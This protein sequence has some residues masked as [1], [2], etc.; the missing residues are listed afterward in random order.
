MDVRAA[1]LPNARGKAKAAGPRHGNGT[2]VL[3]PLRKKNPPTKVG[4]PSSRVR[5]KGIYRAIAG[6]CGA[7]GFRNESGL[8]QRFGRQPY[9]T[10]FGHFKRR[11]APSGISLFYFRLW[12]CS[13]MD[14]HPKSSVSIEQL[15]GQWAVQ[16]L[17]A[18]AVTKRLFEREEF[19]RNYAASQ[20]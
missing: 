15:G 14:E 16:I 8:V 6:G 10:G 20:W 9:S 18:G 17:E 5:W 13:A 3:L 2:L 4:G 12:E 11:S 19:A 7:F 1:R